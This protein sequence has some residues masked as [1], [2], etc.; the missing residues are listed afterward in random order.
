[1][2]HVSLLATGEGRWIPADGA[3]LLD[4]LG[5]PKPD[6]DPVGFVVRNLGFVQYEV[7]A[8]SF[9]QITLFPK[10]VTLQALAA[11]QRRILSDT[12]RVF[13]LDYLDDETKLWTQ[14]LAMN[15]REAIGKLNRLC[16]TYAEGAV[17]EGYEV[18]PLDLGAVMAD[19]R[20]PAHSL[21]RK[22]RS[23]FHQFDDGI[24]PFIAKHGLASQ[25]MVIGIDPKRPEPIFRFI[26]EGYA[27]YGGDYFLRAV[28]QKVADQPDKRYGEWVAPFYSE[29]ASTWQPRLDRC[30]APIKDATRPHLRYERLI[31]PWS[32]ASGEV[33]LTLSTRFLEPE[34]AADAG[35]SDKVLARKPAKSS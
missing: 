24:M 9:A 4:L 17:R 2:Q 19:E 13:R 11:V 5:D 26:G 32:T 1:M 16:G 14:E 8:D 7:F 6:F 18:E 3:A 30:S 15:P 20:H 10:R 33:L 23:A 22:W 21:L 29:V 27:I 12:V 34:A 28:G 31:L 25:S 35:S